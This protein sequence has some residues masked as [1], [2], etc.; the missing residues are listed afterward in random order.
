MLKKIT[1][2]LK[3]AFLGKSSDEYMAQF[4]GNQEYWDHINAAQ[5]A[6]SSGAFAPAP[7]QCENSNDKTHGDSK[8]TAAQQAPR[9]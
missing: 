8:S 9:S 1:R 4:T 5:A 3:R 7:S 2:A 6:V